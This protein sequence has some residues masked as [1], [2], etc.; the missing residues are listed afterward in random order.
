MSN[1]SLF[2][3]TLFVLVFGLSALLGV[4]PAYDVGLTWGALAAI[5]GSTLLYL[6]VAY[7]VRSW[8]AAR[9]VAGTLVTAGVL[10]ALYFITQFSHQNY[11]ETPALIQRLGAITTLLPNLGLI[12]LHPNAVATLLELL[13][14][15]AAALVIASRGRWLKALLAAVVLILAYALLL[16]FSRGAWLGVGAA[17][18]LAVALALL[19]RLPRRTAIA[20]TF[21]VLVL[22]GGLVA[23]AAL[24][25]PERL[26]FLRSTFA[27]ADSRLTLYRNALRLGTDYAFS[28]I[29]LGNTYGMVYS[30][31]S[32]LI[33][34]PQLT[35][36]HNLPLAV[37]LGQGLLGLIALLGIGLTFYSMV[38]RT[39][40]AGEPDALFHGAWLSVTA[41]F[42]HGLTDARQYVESPWAMPMLFVA[43]GLAGALARLAFYNVPAVLVPRHLARRL[44]VAA[45]VAGL[46][47]I[48]GLT[49]NGTLR[50]LWYTNRGTLDETRA[51]LTPGLNDATKAALSNA[52]EAAYRTA[53]ELDPNLPNANRRLGNLYVAL[54]RYDEAV[55]LLEKAAATEADYQA[56]L[57][58]LGLAYVW[59]GR[60]DDAARTLARLRNRQDIINELWTWSTYRDEI[61]QLELSQYASATAELLSRLP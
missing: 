12:Y 22:A 53:L 4:P 19:A 43:L 32:L 5:T 29:G 17:A 28:G 59:A 39:L 41:T 30:R 57:K 49:L 38:Y 42:V 33:F 55:P 1:F 10:A 18:G 35:Y 36:A 34:V 8:A 7:L 58:G 37:W 56:A 14:P 46:L 45:S 15:L 20:L 11:P 16:T 3:L 9:V 50:A 2:P 52:A 47:L 61:N 24:L 13:L 23:A 40:R 31:F 54:E 44:L 21:G 25:G 51:Q 6:L 48:A 60:P 26:P 27:A